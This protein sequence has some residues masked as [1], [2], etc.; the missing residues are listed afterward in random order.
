MKFNIGI[1]GFGS[2]GKRHLKNIILLNRANKVTIYDSSIQYYDHDDK[3]LEI[4][5]KSDIKELKKENLDLVL[6]CT[7]SLLHYENSVHF[8]EN[9]IPVFIEKPLTISAIDAEK[10]KSKR[11]N[12]VFIGCNMRYHIALTKAKEFIDSNNLGQIIY[13]RAYFGH[14]LAQWRSGVDYKKTY[15]AQKENGGGILFDG[16]HEIDYTQW[17][18][19]KF[20][21]YKAFVK[22]LNVLDINVEEIVEIIVEHSNNSTSNIHLDYLQSTKRRGLE[23]VGKE[24]TFIW[25]SAGKLPEKMTIK[26]FSKN[27]IEETIFESNNYDINKCYLKEFEEMFDVLEGKNVDDTSLLTL[28]DAIW[29]IDFIEKVLKENT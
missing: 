16:I 15:S 6:I 13:S 10:I 5:F 23:I 27:Q 25:E 26:Y 7:P 19:G 22:N 1:I 2:I 29:E 9:G 24:G 17:L 21:N 20:T 28:D 8:I 11:I 18:F 14:N 12:H 3:S 4:E